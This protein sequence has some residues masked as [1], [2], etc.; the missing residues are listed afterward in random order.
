ML[1]IS[2]ARFLFPDL[3]LRAGDSKVLV[4]AAQLIDDH[5]QPGDILY[6]VGDG[7]WIDM[8]N[9]SD[10]PE[11]FYKMPLCAPVRG[12]LSDMTREGLG[13][14]VAYLEDI[15]WD[16]AWVITAISPMTPDCEQ[17]IID[18]WLVGAEL[19]GCINKD[20]IKESCVYLIER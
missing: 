2:T 12:A 19:V 18:P 8:I 15:A 20:V 6:H 7:S 11:S 13:V 5:W 3:I 4:Y 9:L 1:T 14:Q 10:H 17:T 16:R